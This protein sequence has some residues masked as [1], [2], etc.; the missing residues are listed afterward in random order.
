MVACC[1]S[2]KPPKTNT[3]TDARKTVSTT[4]SGSDRHHHVMG[5]RHQRDFRT[6]GIETMCRV[7]CSDVYLNDRIAGG[8]YRA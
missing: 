2:K 1:I 7:P 8:G 3:K 4:R 5:N 6:L